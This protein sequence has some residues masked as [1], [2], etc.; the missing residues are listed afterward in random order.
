L[1][2]NNDLFLFHHQDL[3]SLFQVQYL[4]FQGSLLT[5]QKLILSTHSCI[6][7]KIFIKTWST[8]FTK[9]EVKLFENKSTILKEI[10]IQI[11]KGETSENLPNKNFQRERIKTLFEFQTNFLC[12]HELIQTKTKLT[13]YHQNKPKKLN[14]NII[15]N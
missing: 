3:G 15:S 2:T 4:G 10:Y 6:F 5:K 13:I 7:H 8:N 9:T 11:I 1:C 12:E 14:S